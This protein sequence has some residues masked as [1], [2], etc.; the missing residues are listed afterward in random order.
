M[1][2]DGNYYLYF[3]GARRKTRRQYGRIEYLKVGHAKSIKNRFKAIDY[4]C[5]LN[6]KLLCY[7]KSH[8]KHSIL[9]AER[10][11]KASCSL[12][13][14]KGEWYYLYDDNTFDRWFLKNAANIL[15]SEPTWV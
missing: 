11:I 6:L 5:P 7:F 4:M 10:K 15:G 9:K 2:W 12:D 3:I 13:R 8:D 1:D 14:I